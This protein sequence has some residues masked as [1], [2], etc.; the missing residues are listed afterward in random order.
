M[1]N[2]EPF[3]V[4]NRVTDAVIANVHSASPGDVREALATA[5]AAFPIW[6]AT[7]EEQRVAILRGLAD[8]LE[9]HEEE[10]ADWA[11][12]SGWRAARMS[13]SPSASC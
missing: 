13:V 5:V 8:C 1:I 11:S 6:S 7:T 4:E 10:L 9:A 2:G 12:R 3:S